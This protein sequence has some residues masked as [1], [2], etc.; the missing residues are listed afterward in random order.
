MKT[1][2]E[3]SSFS[4]LYVCKREVFFLTAPFFPLR[5]KVPV[6]SDNINGGSSVPRSQERRRSL[7]QGYVGLSTDRMLR[8]QREGGDGAERTGQQQPG[9]LEDDCQLQ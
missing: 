7:S 3:K 5:F 1:L 8:D 2:E 9:S 6:E 4:V